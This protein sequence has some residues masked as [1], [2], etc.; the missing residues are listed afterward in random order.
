MVDVSHS[1]F[2]SRKKS[3]QGKNL[4]TLGVGVYNHVNVERSIVQS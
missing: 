4:D 2:L 3:V 1:M